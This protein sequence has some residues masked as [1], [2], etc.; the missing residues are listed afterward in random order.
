MIDFEA[1]LVELKNGRLRAAIDWPAPTKEFL[2]LPHH[3]WY[4]TNNHAAYNTHSVIKLCSDMGTQ[5]LLNL[6]DK[7]EDEH[8]VL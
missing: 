5:S 3:I 2:E 1:L 8:Q 4:N 7:G 6:L